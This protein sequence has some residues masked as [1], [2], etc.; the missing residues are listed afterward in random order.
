MSVRHSNKHYRPELDGLRAIAVISVILYHAELTIFGN[1][2]WYQGGYIGVDVFFVISG[3]LITRIILS[4]LDKNGSFSFLNFYERRA[5][6]ILP[7]LFLVIFVSVPFAWQI[8]LPTE[9]IEFAQS[10]LSSLA[11][12]SNFFFYFT[13]TQYGADS[14]LLKPFLHTWSLGIEE[15][16]YLVFPVLAVT[17]FKYARNY[18]IWILI[19]LA[20][21]SLIY[22]DSIALRFPEKNFY[23]PFSRFWEL[24]AGSFLAYRELF[25]RREHSYTWSRFY[26][27]AGLCLIMYSLFSFDDRTIHPG[28]DTIIP[29]L[30]VSLIIG[31]AS[32]HDLVGKMLGTRPLVGIGLIS[33]SAY[34]WHFPIFALA[35]N[36]KLDPTNIDKY[37]WI[38]LTFL[39]S[40]ASYFLVERVFRNRVRVLAKPFLYTTAIS[41]ASAVLVCFMIMSGLVVNRNN[42][43]IANLIDRGV[44]RKEQRSFEIDYDYSVK[45]NEKKSLLVVGDSHAE[46]LFKAMSF[47]YLN[48]Q[49]NLYM[50]S[51]LKRDDDINYEIVCLYNYLVDVDTVCR[52]R[53]YA[54]NIVQQYESSDVIVLGGSWD[55]DIDL[56]VLPDL[57]TR[58]IADDK[59]VIVVSHT[60]ESKTFGIRGLNRFD[61][62]LFENRRL[63]TS[64]ELRE[65]EHRFYDDYLKLAS[66][67]KKLMSSVSEASSRLVNFADRSE[68]MCDKAVKKCSLYFERTGAK[69]LWDY[70]HITTAG[71]GKLAKKID[72]IN[73]LSEII[74]DQ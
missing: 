13:T 29:V 26:P 71:A 28:F 70:G 16:Y 8:L 14:A 64:V 41:S 46:D 39:L 68:Y 58:L 72:E 37:Q 56:Q 10:I 73:W 49:F 55:D 25:F 44:Y 20:L 38:A 18:F 32:S 7:V 5:R 67:N 61:A 22:A 1:D 48:E 19:T 3:Y 15:Q 63:P 12:G 36:A 35:R 43:E 62:F 6:R 34:M 40:V 24:S 11:F 65:L 30:G 69:V 59:E 53:E 66:L 60:P 4:E 51:P 23:L 27:L 47:S 52:N 45:T 33:Y 21:F 17:L 57:L 54:P 42:I 50:A 74:V 9:F 31:Y 2:H